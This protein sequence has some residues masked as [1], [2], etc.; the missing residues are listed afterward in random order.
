[1]TLQEKEQLA[2]KMEVGAEED[3]PTVWLE[4]H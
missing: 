4:Q 3:F 1:M 2:N